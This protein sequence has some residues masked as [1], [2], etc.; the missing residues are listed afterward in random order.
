MEMTEKIYAYSKII[1]DSGVDENP[2]EEIYEI[3]D[4]FKTYRI[5]SSMGPEN[6][7]SVFNTARSRCYKVMPQS[8]C[9]K[10]IGVSLGLLCV[11]LLP[12]II[13]LHTRLIAEKD[14][15]QAS[16]NNV[17]RERDQLQA[18]YNSLMLERP[19]FQTSYN[20]TIER[21]QLQDKIKQLAQEK[22]KWETSYNTTVNQLDEL[23]RERDGLHKRVT[24]CGCFRVG[25]RIK[26]KASV[27]SPKYG[28]GD[29]SHKSVGVVT[30]LM[31]DRLKVDFPDHK[32]WLAAVSEIELA[33]STDPGY[34]RVGDRVRV[35]ASVS[36]PKYKW[37]EASHRSVGV[38][39]AVD[40][41]NMTVDFPEHKSWKAAV[42]EMELAPSAD[43]ENFRVGDRV[44][45]KASVSTPKY[46]WGSASHSS[47][48]V[49]RAISGETMTVDFPVQKSWKAAV[50]EME[51]A[52]SEDSETFRIGDQVRVKASVSTP[53]YKWGSASHR[54][55]GVVT[56]LA[57]ESM[58]VDF[59]EHKSWKAL[60][61]EM[62]LAPSA[63]PRNFRIGDEVR[64]KASVSS[65]TFAWA[66]ASN[67][68]VGVVTA[69]SGESMT[70]DFPEHKSWKAAVSEMELAPSFDSGNFR[71][72]DGV[73]VKA[74]VSAPK[75]GWGS[76]SH[77]SVGVVTAING[78]SMTVSF[79]EHKVWTAAVSEMELAPSSDS[80][81]F[82]VGD[83][84]RVKASVSSPKYKWGS[85]SHSSVGVVTAVTGDSMTVDFPEQKSWKAV[86]SEMELAPSDNS[87]NFRV[88]DRVRV[89]A[90]VS[91]PKYGWGSA[92]HSAVGV[93]TA[94]H[95]E[96][97]NVDFPDH[98]SWMAAISEM[99]LAPSVDSE[100]FRVGDRVRV[101]ATVSSPKYDWG[102]ASHRSVGVVTAVDGET[103]T[104]DFP[105]H[106]S[107][108][109]AVSEMELAPSVDSET[110]RVGDRVRV[111]TSVS[112]PKYGWGDASRRSVGVV[113]GV[114]GESM[115]V[116]FPEHKSWK[117][118]V[119]EMELAPSSDSETFRVGD[120]VRVKTSVS[121][122]KYG[123]G[124]ASRR[125]VGVVTGVNGE[126][127]TVDFPEHKSWKAAVSEMELAPSSDSETF[128]VGDRV[129]VKTSVSSPKYGWGTATRRSVGV[130]T[131]VNGES[132]TVDFPEH[133]SWKAAVSEMELAPSSDSETFRVGDRVRVKTSVSSPKYGWGTATRRSVGVVKV[134]SGERMTVDFPGHRSWKAAVSEM[135][136]APSADSR[137]FRIGDEVRV[138]ASV[139]SPK[140]MWGSVS[141]KSVGVVTAIS[142]E[143]ITVDFPEHKS[144]KAAASEMELAPSFDSG[145]F[146]D[147]DRV[148]VK[149]SVSTPKYRWGDASHRSVGVV[150]AVNG[151]I[152]TVDF[153]EHKSWKSTVF[154]MELAPSTDSGHFRVGDRVRVKASVTTPKYKWGDASHSSVGVVTA[155][156][157]ES[158][159]VD[160]PEHKSWMATV[161][162]MELAP[163]AD[164]ENFRVGDR[165]R[166]K[167]SIS[168]PKYGWGS[169]SHGSIGVVTAINGDSMT[170]NYPEHKNWKAA[171][172]EME[173]APSADLGNFRVGDRVRVKASVSSP[174]YDWGHASHGSVGVVTAVSGESMTVDF[175]EHKSWKAAV[176][177]MELAPNTDSGNF[178]I[179]DRVR[180]KASVRI[181]KY[182]W[183]SAS[184]S[185]VGVV[186]AINGESMM[187]D[188]PDHRSW[189]AAVSEMELAPSE[190]SENFRVGDRVRVKASVSSPKYDWG[191]ASHRSVGVVTAVNGDTLTVDFPEHKS[192]KA[193]VSDMEL[194]PS[195]D[196]MG[197]ETSWTQSPTE[198]LN[199]TSK[200]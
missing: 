33:S 65:P 26:V 180:V 94:I 160:F 42:S 162:E 186:T 45:V 185:S 22:E 59:P 90:S 145:N 153:P 116:D 118:A 190:D 196:S 106:R 123:W 161:S 58:T 172:S 132:M 31:D 135:E 1:D 142:G 82:R 6:L 147:G 8:R 91:S 60:V 24:D 137:N 54:S 114:N 4:N 57:G 119:S 157:G 170:V 175:P 72:G 139:S 17:T 149:A 141:N 11:L 2:N 151:E 92:S 99:E 111:K 179:G 87:Q 69:I 53:K 35:K 108:K 173:L 46:K 150:T 70:I 110:F 164:L 71:V 48:G 105:E 167:A 200:I 80:A 51:L 83:R 163:S 15:L 159:T 47:V 41:E 96:S 195:T 192:W 138:K 136:L 127:M 23:Q 133:K 5:K 76:A 189:K 109:A 131:G 156:N 56:A 125:S 191:S 128:R 117:A 9:Y 64:V 115:T 102:H 171:V 154:E 193:A 62:E 198:S 134:I 182:K 176:S 12:I 37:G 74:S 130:V 112:S 124:D 43:S 129:R 158:M 44:R 81:N 95:G 165:V 122:P 144:W 120:R 39:T 181:P 19:Q 85:A 29:A 199:T 174:K 197:L 113:T 84:V 187:V 14:R 63:D 55:V 86:V 168:S 38:V 21:D 183:G 121:S 10:V 107:W 97:M 20:V 73:R 140:Y 30:A 75:Y 184:H 101:K 93:V 177:E 3:E 188:F 143:S 166:V 32:S 67:K 148:R 104:V 194:A 103:M 77:R 178:R 52:P 100:T 34:F 7:V 16:Y 36:T 126:S 88:G 61:S 50:S 49:V 146:R 13:V 25:D 79:P 78:E 89:K 27:T 66:H 18:S 155:I 169:A 152:I 98:K 68:S 40:G 28:W